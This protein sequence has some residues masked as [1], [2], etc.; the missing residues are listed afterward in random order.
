MLKFPSP[1]PNA[2]FVCTHQRPD[3]ELI[4]GVEQENL[5]QILMEAK[6]E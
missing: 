1:F 5:V 2:I 6:G 4:M 3:G